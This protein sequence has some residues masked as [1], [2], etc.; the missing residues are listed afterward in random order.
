MARDECPPFA[1]GESFYN[2]GPIDTTNLGGV[3]LEG[4]EFLVEDTIYGT[5]SPVRLRVV[6]N[7]ST[8][9]IQAKRLVQFDP[10]YLGKRVLG[11]AATDLQFAYPS[12][13]LIGPNGIVPNDL[14]YVV[15]QGPA[16]ILTSDAGNA[17]A[18]GDI[19]F[20]QTQAASTGVTA[21]RI[22]TAATTQ[23]GNNALNYIG[24]AL[25][26]CTAGQTAQPL[27]IGVKW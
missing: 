14:F 7:T 26:A 11:Y 12:D 23:N 9:N 2:G 4:K 27:V 6:R 17:V 18:A 10:A 16:A 3:N 15:V 1:R 13:E 8:V 22:V 25:S 5:G 19:V 24:R 20:A 21:G